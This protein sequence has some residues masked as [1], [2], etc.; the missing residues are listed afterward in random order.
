MPTKRFSILKA[1]LLQGPSDSSSLRHVFRVMLGPDPNLA[2]LQGPSAASR[3]LPT[4][5]TFELQAPTALD[6]HEWMAHIQV[7][8]CLWQEGQASAHASACKA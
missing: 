6:L 5:A 4:P 8:T 7:G 3:S 2:L 1:T